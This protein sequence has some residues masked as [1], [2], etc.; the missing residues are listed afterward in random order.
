MKAV[1]FIIAILSGF[2]YNEFKDF[3]VNGGLEHK[4]ALTLLKI[5]I[6]CFLILLLSIF[7]VPVRSLF[8]ERNN[9]TPETT[10]VSDTK[11]VVAS[12]KDNASRTTRSVS[13]RRRARFS[14]FYSE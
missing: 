5:F 10:P 13:S 1:I 4:L 2:L 6:I 8:I 11:S 3:L 14:D 9:N 7:E 12:V